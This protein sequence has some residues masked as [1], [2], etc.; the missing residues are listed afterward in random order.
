M[1]KNKNSP[2]TVEEIQA[3]TA[4]LNAVREKMAFVHPLTAVERRQAGRMGTQL[5]RFTAQRL[6]AARQHRDALPASFDLRQFERDTA[7]LLALNDCVEAASRI[8]QD[9][10]DTLLSLGNSAV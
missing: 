5:V 10:R 9:T 2:P 6:Q 3:A 8:R 4:A 7:L 1:N